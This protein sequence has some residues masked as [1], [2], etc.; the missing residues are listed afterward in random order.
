MLVFIAEAQC[1]PIGGCDADGA[2]TSSI[3][4][5]T[6]SAGVAACVAAARLDA[7]ELRASAPLSGETLAGVEQV[8]IRVASWNVR[9][10]RVGVRLSASAQ[11][12]MAW[13]DERLVDT[14][15]DLVALQE[16]DGSMHV[17]RRLRRWFAPRGFEVAVLPSG[18][19]GV[20]VAWRT[21]V[22][23]SRGDA[24]ALA[25]CTLGV[26]L[27]RLAY[28]AAVGVVCMHGPHESE[29]AVEVQ[30]R[31]AAVW[32]EAQ[33]GGLLLGDLNRVVCTSWR[34]SAAFVVKTA[35]KLLRAWR[36]SRGCKAVRVAHTCC[37]R[38]RTRMLASQRCVSHMLHRRRFSR[39]LSYEGD[40]CAA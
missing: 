37:S 26:P 14:R 23:A 25:D 18:S 9:K 7:R 30:L 4:A 6:V 11:E 1:A 3:S 12:K 21:E 34:R 16:L 39:T 27:T 38:P 28:A 24:K 8:E 20:A 15:V 5:V 36:N 40:G 33:E 29:A 22:F 35:Y 10:L 17:L 13:L 32:L 19:R 31:S 2:R